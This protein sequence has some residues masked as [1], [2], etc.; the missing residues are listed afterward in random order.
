[1]N[2]KQTPI[3]DLIDGLMTNSESLLFAIPYL[4]L[5]SIGTAIKL[6]FLTLL[7][8]LSFNQWIKLKNLW[9]I[10]FLKSNLGNPWNFVLTV[11]L[12]IILGLIL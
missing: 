11:T 1:M 7:S 2:K 12:F 10:G 6:T 3:L 9:N 5:T 4:I 8:I